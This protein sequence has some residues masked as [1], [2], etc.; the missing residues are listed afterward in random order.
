[1]LGEPRPWARQ[2]YHG[3]AIPITYHKG[4]VGLW[5]SLLRDI[6]PV[7]WCDIVQYLGNVIWTGNKLLRM[8][9]PQFRLSSAGEV[10]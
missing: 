4:E 7:W 9:Y 3:M 6:E 8:W 2:G 1:M 10:S 5:E